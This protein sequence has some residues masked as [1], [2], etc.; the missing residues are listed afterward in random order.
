VN[1][2]PAVAKDAPAI[3]AIWNGI[4]RETDATFTTQ[5]KSPADLNIPLQPYFVADADGILGFATY[6]QFRGGPG[7]RH[8]MEHSV[9]LL[10]QAQGRGAGRAL[11]DALEDHARLAGIHSLWAGISGTNEAGVAFHRAIGFEHVARLPEVGEKWGRRYD[12]VL[13]RKILA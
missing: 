11:M 5:E 7:Y 3:C 12:L 9:H 10:P 1:I 2:R 8:T 13:M 6:F 4:I